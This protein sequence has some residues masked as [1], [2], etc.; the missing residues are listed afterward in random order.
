MH[1]QPC[2]GGLGYR[3]GDLP[4]SERASREVLPLPVFYGITSEEV[5]RI[6]LTV[7]RWSGR[8]SSVRCPFSIE[9]GRSRWR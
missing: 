1:L 3:V 6:C 5:E 4:E 7:N 2:F 9:G 8:T